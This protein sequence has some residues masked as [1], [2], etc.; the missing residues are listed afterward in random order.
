MQFARQKKLHTSRPD[1][2]AEYTDQ[3]K[4]VR[5]QVPNGEGDGWS[6]TE[7]YGG[8]NRQ[9]LCNLRHRLW[10]DKGDVMVEYIIIASVIL[11]AFTVI[12]PFVWGDGFPWERIGVSTAI[13]VGWGL[14]MIG[15]LFG[16]EVTPPAAIFMSVMPVIF[17]WLPV[18][19]LGGFVGFWVRHIG[20]VGFSACMA[21]WPL[22]VFACLAFLAWRAKPT[23][24]YLPVEGRTGGSVDFLAK[25]ENAK[26]CDAVVHLNEEG[27]SDISKED[28]DMASMMFAGFQICEKRAGKRIKIVAGLILIGVLVLISGFIASMAYAKSV[29]ATVAE[30]RG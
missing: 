14:I 26:A 5:K 11:I 6:H 30:E 19:I 27:Q 13:S 12:L 29:V 24:T 28:M 20:V 15:A 9:V 2:Y 10:E 25:R 22:L 3:F 21:F 1:A 4:V 16:E 18:F 23:K 17:I 7:T 8:H